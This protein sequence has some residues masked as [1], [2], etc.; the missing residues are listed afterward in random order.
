M[1]N[2]LNLLPGTSVATTAEIISQAKQDIARRILVTAQLSQPLELSDLDVLARINQAFPET[3]SLGAVTVSGIGA[4]ADAPAPANGGAGEVVAQSKRTNIE[5]AALNAIMGAGGDTAATATLMGRL[6]RIAEANEAITPDLELI[7]YQLTAGTDP[8][9]VGYVVQ[10][11]GVPEVRAFGTNAVIVPFDTR[12]SSEGGGATG[13]DI[14]AIAP[15]RY[16]LIQ[17]PTAEIDL[18]DVLRLSRLI[19]TSQAGSPVVASIWQNETQGTVLT[20]DPVQADLE[21][22]P[23]E[24]VAIATAIR[25]SIGLST[26]TTVPAS[27]GVTATIQGLLRRLGTQIDTLVNPGTIVNSLT[28]NQAQ[29]KAAPGQLLSIT[30]IN[31][32]NTDLFLQLHD[33]AGPVVDATNLLQTHPIFGDFSA[34]VLD[35]AVFGAEGMDFISG[36]TWVISTDA[37]NFTPAGAN[38]AFVYSRFR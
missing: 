37:V 12:L 14:E 32:T 4:A 29:V 20:V 17:N 34:V 24:L 26:D 13:P 7:E 1:P 8:W 28:G 25:D 15:L 10:N 22:V 23:D 3:A 18:N 36:I 33:S 2:T 31:R 27:Y 35:G 38:D 6:T 5:L 21:T 30:A 19:D 9:L 16:Q 11:A